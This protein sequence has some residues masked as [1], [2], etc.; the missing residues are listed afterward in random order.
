MGRRPPR[1]RRRPPTST[2]GTDLTPP[3]AQGRATLGLVLAGHERFVAFLRR[4]LRDEA[5]AED[6]L[7]S[8]YASVLARNAAP[9]DRTRVV[10][11]FYRV[12]RRALLDHLRREASV[13]RK[14]EGRAATVR[15]AADDEGA[16]R[17]TVCACVTDLLPSLRPEYA[18]V[19]RHVEIEQESVRETAGKLGITPSNAAVRVHRAR[20]ALARKLREVCGACTTHG[21]LRCTCHASGT[22]P[23]V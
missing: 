12:L 23:G 9:R 16:L 17:S 6:V 7:Q 15:L 14:L 5:A 19:L 11:W 8:A 13:R 3:D 4:R 20:T 2:G 1:R 21:C 18:E 10:A 22:R